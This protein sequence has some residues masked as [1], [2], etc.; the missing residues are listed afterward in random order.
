MGGKLEPSAP[1]L[2]FSTPV[3]CPEAEVGDVC[4]LPGHQ[5]SGGAS[6]SAWGGTS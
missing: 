5:G 1:P 2:S 3:G 6:C 4:E